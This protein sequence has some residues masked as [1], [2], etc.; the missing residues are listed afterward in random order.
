MSAERTSLDIAKDVRG[1]CRAMD[2][3]LQSHPHEINLVD[4]E[5]VREAVNES[6]P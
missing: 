1:S 4:A 5:S 6:I 2:Q 3:R